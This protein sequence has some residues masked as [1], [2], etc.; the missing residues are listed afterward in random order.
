MV[1]VTG[2]AFRV[3]LMGIIALMIDICVEMYDLSPGWS[4]HGMR[5]MM[6]CMV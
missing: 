6:S 5:A 4:R 1:V 2:D 3:F